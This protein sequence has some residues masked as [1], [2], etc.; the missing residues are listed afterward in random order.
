MR[1]GDGWGANG[2]VKKKEGRKER[3]REESEGEERN[4]FNTKV[5]APT[6]RLLK[7]QIT[8]AERAALA[9]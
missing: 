2:R 8:K 1:N 9:H 7:L 5:F 3:E 6:H 4:H